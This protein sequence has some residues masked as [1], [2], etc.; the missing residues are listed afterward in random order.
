[1]HDNSVLAASKARKTVPASSQTPTIDMTMKHIEAPSV[2][3]DQHLLR[4]KVKVSIMLS[5]SP[6][7]FATLN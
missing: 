4:A 6:F 5:S 3:Q 1:M 2:S 7:S